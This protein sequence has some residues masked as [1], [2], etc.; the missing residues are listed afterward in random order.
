MRADLPDD[1]WLRARALDARPPQAEWSTIYLSDGLSRSELAHLLGE[2]PHK[3]ERFVAR[4]HR[5][6]GSR[7]QVS[8]RWRRSAYLGFW[9]DVADAA[10]ARKLARKAG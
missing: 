3:L 5:D 9:R 8:D 10:D 7:R 1:G 6:A 2:R 4:W